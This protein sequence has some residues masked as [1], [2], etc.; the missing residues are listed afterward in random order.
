MRRFIVAALAV[1][2]SCGG[3]DQ[4]AEETEPIEFVEEPEAPSLVRIEL[5]NGIVAFLQEDHY[6][7][8]V[9][10]EV[11][12]RA[13]FIHEP[14]GQVQISHLTEHI[15]ANAAT[16][17]YGVGAA[18]AEIGRIGH[19]GAHAQANCVR[20]GYVVGAEDIA[21]AFAIEV[22]R[23]T[24]AVIDEAIVVEQ[25]GRAVR[26][27]EYILS[28]RGD[29]AMTRFAMIAL[30]QILRYG[31]T[32][33]P[34]YTEP[35]RITAEQ[36]ANFHA[37]YYRPDDMVIVLTGGFDATEVESLLRKHFAKIP[38]RPAPPEVTT[39]ISGDVSA[40]WDVR[41]DVFFLVF[42]GPYTDI[43]ERI[44]L[45]MFGSYFRK[46]ISTITELQ[47]MTLSVYTSSPVYPVGEVPF[48]IFGQPRSLYTSE[49]LRN[50]IETSLASAKTGIDERMLRAIKQNTKAFMESSNLTQLTGV[51]Q[52]DK[53]LAKEA[54]SIAFK[55]IFREGMSDDE[56]YAVIDAITVDDMN[57]IIDRLL[58]DGNRRVVTLSGL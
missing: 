14:D 10:I 48:F 40:R 44:A 31:R 2:A 23:L 15:I 12:Y 34:V 8:R 6:D 27:I 41:A 56:L 20:F 7:S 52:R 49:E 28:D 45:A 17:S 53:D 11:F 30:C 54:A 57:N 29:G 9:G 36:V 47:D 26:E 4:P 43:R 21:T 22:E 58:S 13:G 19:S 37:T 33:V 1:V 16:A 18:L 42:P 32:R 50:V 5:D 35:F 55:H 24:S 38:R 25:V 46:Y 51:V 3:E 39:S